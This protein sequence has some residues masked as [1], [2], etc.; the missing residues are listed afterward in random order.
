MAE[1]PVKYVI[2]ARYGPT[3]FSIPY[4]IHHYFRE[5]MAIFADKDPDRVLIVQVF[6]GLDGSSEFYFVRFNQNGLSWELVAIE[7]IV[8]YA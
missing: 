3:W 5:R 4:K 6:D 1:R 2:H 8:K 7:G